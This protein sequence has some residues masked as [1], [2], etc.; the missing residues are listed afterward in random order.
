MLNLILVMH[1]QYVV[2][3]LW[4]K[5]TLVFGIQDEF[6][7]FCKNYWQNRTHIMY[8][9]TFTSVDDEST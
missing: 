5:K 9:F 7:Q 4:V 3:K 6:P 1:E 2:S 8:I